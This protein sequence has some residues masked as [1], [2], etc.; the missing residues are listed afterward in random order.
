MRP[1]TEEETRT[2]FTKLAA[3][4]GKSVTYEGVLNS[5][6]ALVPANFAW[7]DDVPKT[8]VP[9]PGVTRIA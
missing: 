2:L 8:P 1:L 6:E 4:T 5:Q 3:Y 9:V 7:N